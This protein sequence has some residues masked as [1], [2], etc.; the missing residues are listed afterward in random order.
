MPSC[1]CTSGFPLSLSLSLS[2]CFRTN[3]H[4]KANFLKNWISS[5]SSDTES[6]SKATS[7]HVLRCSYIFAGIIS[8]LEQGCYSS[9][10]NEFWR[11]ARS[12]ER[13]CYIRRYDLYPGLYPRWTLLPCTYIRNAETPSIYT[14]NT[15]ADADIRYA[16]VSPACNACT[17]PSSSFPPSRAVNNSIGGRF[18]WLPNEE[19]LHARRRLSARPPLDVLYDTQ[20]HYSVPPR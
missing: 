9:E 1:S 2:R 8:L 4:L 13:N 16:R 10:M 12:S 18:L 14:R 20:R 19:R 7:S 6:I 11:F 5:C 15:D 3:L 17:T